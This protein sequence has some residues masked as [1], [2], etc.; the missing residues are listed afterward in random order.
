MCFG[1]LFVLPQSGEMDIENHT[2]KDVCHLKY[3]AYNYFGRD[4][5]RKVDKSSMY[6]LKCTE[7]PLWSS[8]KKKKEKE[9]VQLML[10]SVMRSIKGYCYPLCLGVKCITGCW[11]AWQ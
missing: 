6:Q 5:P 2:T 7:V 3:D 1:S 11:V 4:T 10:A 9:G 8:S